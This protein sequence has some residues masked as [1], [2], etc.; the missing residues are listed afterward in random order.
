MR[1]TIK[2]AKTKT[3][4][5]RNDQKLPEA[6]KAIEITQKPTERNKKKHKKTKT[7]PKLRSDPK[8]PEPQPK[9]RYNNHH[10]LRGATK[11]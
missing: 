8:L 3:K 11:K 5:C 4:N 6:T 7:T 9:N 1:A 10:K 2:T